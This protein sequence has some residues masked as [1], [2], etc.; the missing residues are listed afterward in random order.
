MIIGWREYIGLPDLGLQS[1]AAKIDTGART[2]AIHADEIAIFEK[3]GARWVRFCV[4]H[5]AHGA[6]HHSEAPILETRKIKN[7][8]GVPEERIVI[9]TQLALGKRHWRIDLSLADRW[10]MNFPVIV[11]RASLSHHRIAVDTGRSYLLRAP[12]KKSKKPTGNG[13]RE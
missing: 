11:G 6:D 9:R 10:N 4:A 3:A 2:S 7:T 13:T 8:G 12:D 1:L 5:A